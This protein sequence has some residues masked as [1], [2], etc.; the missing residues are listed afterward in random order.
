MPNISIQRKEGIPFWIWLIV[1]LFIV[2]AVVLFGL[3]GD[4]RPNNS[5]PQN[6]TGAVIEFNQ[7]TF[8]T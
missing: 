1:A 5:V 4:N 6:Q 2:L 3:R 7:S 8:L